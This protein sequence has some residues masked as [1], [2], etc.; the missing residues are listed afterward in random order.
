[1][2]QTENDNTN[3][4]LL[5]I[6]D[7]AGKNSPKTVK[8]IHGL[9]SAVFRMYRPD[10]TLNTTL[11]Q[12][13]P[14]TLYIPTDNDV[15]KLINTIGDDEDMMI[16]VLLAAFGPLRRSEICGVEDTDT[17]LFPTSYLPK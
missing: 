6:N 12:K 10:M 7:N 14:K 2:V 5:L 15:A 11:P 8:N 17:S 9:I 4:L 16:A 3:H 13:V 1:M